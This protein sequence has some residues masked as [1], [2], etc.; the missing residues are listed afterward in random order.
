MTIELPNTKQEGFQWSDFSKAVLDPKA[1]A[2]KLDKFAESI[3]HAL[4][5]IAR[6]GLMEFNIKHCNKSLSLALDKSDASPL[7][8]THRD[9]C[10]QF[11]LELEAHQQGVLFEYVETESVNVLAQ[12]RLG[13]GA[14]LTHYRVFQPC[15]SGVHFTHH[16]IEVARGASYD[17]VVLT[18]GAELQ[19][20]DSRITLTDEGAHA[21]LRVASFMKDETHCDIGAEMLHLAAD[22]QSMFHAHGVLKDKART[23]FRPTGFIQKGSTG[24]KLH[25]LT[26]SLLLS[27]TA[28]MNAKPELA[29]YHDNVECSHGVASASLD[30]NALF[31]L[32]A[33]GI[34]AQEARQI[35]LDAFI[36]E[37]FQD[38]EKALTL[39][40]IKLGAL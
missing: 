28:V 25:Q 31:Y 36:A 39:A 9:G 18:S 6:N 11:S 1:T 29:I 4:K 5:F 22:T 2:P 38:D 21:R 10:A 40:Q 13:E 12:I 3:T 35:L 33:R 27:E 19:R 16:E 32:L 20:A 37:L 23:S 17:G 26:K 15:D 14:R 8:L 7:Y 34:D 30:E 24:A